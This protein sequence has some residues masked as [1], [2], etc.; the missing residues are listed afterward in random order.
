MRSPPSAV[1]IHRLRR[2]RFGLFAHVCGT[3][4]F[5]IPLLATPAAAFVVDDARAA[6]AAARVFAHSVLH[7]VRLMLFHKPSRHGRGLGHRIDASMRWFFAA[8][9]LTRRRRRLSAST[10]IVGSWTGGPPLRRRKHALRVARMR[11]EQRVS[12]SGVGRM[13]GVLATSPTNSTES[14]G[15]RDAFHPKMSARSAWARVIPFMTGGN[16]NAHTLTTS[17]SGSVLCRFVTAVGF[18][19]IACCTRWLLAS[20]EGCA[21]VRSTASRPGVRR[22]GCR[23][24]GAG[25]RLVTPPPYAAD[26]CCIPAASP[27]GHSRPWPPHSQCLFATSTAIGRHSL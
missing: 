15:A 25:G 18:R 6:S 2:W 8:S 12:A 17:C 10:P 3:H 20:L 26:S 19:P 7:P 9:W 11:E 13:R 23:E 16:R 5:A 1:I 21:R 24:W 14:C 22:I 4:F 27:H